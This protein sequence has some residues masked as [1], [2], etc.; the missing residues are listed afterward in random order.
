MWACVCAAPGRPRPTPLARPAAR[1]CGRALR[2]SVG[3]VG[4][5]SG[6]GGEHLCRMNV[7]EICAQLGRCRRLGAAPWRGWSTRRVGVA[8]GIGVGDA[9]PSCL[10]GQ[11]K[12]LFGRTYP[13]AVFSPGEAAWRPLRGRRHARARL[14]TIRRPSGCSGQIVGSAC[15]RS[16]RC[17]RTRPTIGRCC[18]RLGLCSRFRLRSRSARSRYRHRSTWAC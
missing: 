18:R 11:M 2:H 9:G 7:A 10:F 15:T 1:A 17:M 12:S 13:T 16:R 6:R 5:F 8:I 4:R 3:R 14:N